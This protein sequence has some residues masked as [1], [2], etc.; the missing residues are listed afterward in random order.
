MYLAAAVLAL[1]FYFLHLLGWIDF[2]ERRAADLRL[3][4]RGERPAHA[5]I[6]VIEIDDASL[7]A[8]GEW[9]WKRS[10]HA[11]LIELVSRYDPAAVFF[12]VLFTEASA[13]EE[14]AALAQSVRQNGRVLLPFFYVREA[15]FEAVR[16]LTELVQAAA[17]TAYVNMEPDADGVIRR[18]RAWL[19]TP[20]AVYLHPAL[21]LEGLADAAAP[22]R[23]NRLPRDK[24]H[25]VWI[26]Y[27]G[28]R[29]SFRRISVR[30]LFALEEK[31]E[32]VA[33]ENLLRDKLLLIGHTATGT[34]DLRTTPFGISVPGLHIQASALDT[35]LT[36]RFIYPLPW[37]AEALVLVFLALVAARF[38]RFSKIRYALA[39][40]AGL[41]IGYLLLN[42]TLYLLAG[43][44]LPFYLALAIML[45]VFAAGGILQF[46]E[47][48]FQSELMQN[49]LGMAARLQMQ[50]LPP[51]RAEMPGLDL[52]FDCRFLK[53]VGGD[54]YDW[55]ELAPGQVA[56]ALGD[57]S[58]KGMPA[59]LYM[60][61][62]IS[63]FRRE[64]RPEARP[65]QVQSAVNRHLS[66]DSG[67]MFLTFF[68]AIADS[69]R[70]KVFFSSA[71]HGPA[72]FYRAAT[73]TAEWVEAGEGS[74]L[75]LFDGMEFT[76][77]E[78]TVAPGDMLMVVTDGITEW[79]G[80]GREMYGNERLRQ[81]LEE[82]G[83]EGRSAGETVQALFAALEVFGR[84]APHDDRTVLC[85]KFK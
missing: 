31:G 43:L 32:T 54:L 25:Q 42:G 35:L 46:L 13:P 65:S 48:R 1:L 80:A 2:Q 83:R 67:G 40:F 30:E 68:Y 49:E 51:A 7:E 41:L 82:A 24:K 3:H 12:D 73:Q 21:A 44:L 79:R 15:P 20:E 16:P 81:F 69:A 47:S 26:A 29:E 63:E 27:P 78:T 55:A 45:A 50:F 17:A 37:P 58:G 23:W 76:E 60:A 70:R 38:S 19:K 66:E 39:A 61:R 36:R 8:F 75:G 77:A 53:S 74:P 5:S 10:R 14:D 4:W 56:M 84:E 64:R 6:V 57:V 33:L 71:G 52:A 34:T 28:G 85:A 18:F 9:P 59:A 62:A 72:L 22:P 11:A